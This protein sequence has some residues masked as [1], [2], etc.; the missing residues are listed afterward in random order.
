MHR[1]RTR[2]LRLDEG[3]TGRRA[4]GERPP[5]DTHRAADAVFRVR[6]AAGAITVNP[7]RGLAAAFVIIAE[8]AADMATEGT[9]DVSK[10][11]PKFD[12]LLKTGR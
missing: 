1:R 2:P 10:W 4:G 9:D 5:L 8:A 3:A 12:F 6:A 7:G 11:K